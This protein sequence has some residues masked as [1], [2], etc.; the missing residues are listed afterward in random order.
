MYVVYQCNA[1]IIHTQVVCGA[2]HAL[3]ISQGDLCYMWGRHGD[4]FTTSPVQVPEVTKVTEVAASY[5]VHMCVLEAENGVYAFGPFV[6]LPLVSMPRGLP[7]RR[8]FKPRKPELT[9]FLCTDV[10]FAAMSKPQVMWRALR[11]HE[12]LN[13]SVATLPAPISTSHLSYREEEGNVTIIYAT[14]VT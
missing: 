2:Y 4:R 3:A 7:L 10:P 11:L 13:F 6:D 12:Q 5:L 1:I 9:D 8:D 14:P